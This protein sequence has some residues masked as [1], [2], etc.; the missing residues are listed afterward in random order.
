M[1]TSLFLLP[2]SSDT[3]W[4]WEEE[5]VNLVMGWGRKEGEKATTKVLGRQRKGEGRR[6]ESRNGNKERIPPSSHPGPF[7]CFGLAECYL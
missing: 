3:K 6:E 5:P 7:A 1:S 2:S 4:E